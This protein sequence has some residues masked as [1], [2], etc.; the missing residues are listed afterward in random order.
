LRI[1]LPGF[2]AVSAMALVKA[3][4]S[5]KLSELPR[6]RRYTGDLVDRHYARHLH[7]RGG[8]EGLYLAADDGRPRHHGELHARQTDIGAI[9]GLA[10][11]DVAKVDDLGLA[12]THERELFGRLEEKGLAR[13]HRQRHGRFC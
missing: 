13:R 7:G 11:G 4:D 6:Y 3:T 9:R 12:L 8:I 2:A 10:H 1:T 5:A